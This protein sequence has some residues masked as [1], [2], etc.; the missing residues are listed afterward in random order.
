MF[1]KSAL[2]SL[3]LVASTASAGDPYHVNITDGPFVI[4]TVTMHAPDTNDTWH[5]RTIAEVRMS[6]TSSKIVKAGT[7][8]YQVF[9]HGVPNHIAEG[10]FT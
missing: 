6:G 10:S 1:V 3:G 9:E 8:Q 4:N 2:L 5:E 7:L